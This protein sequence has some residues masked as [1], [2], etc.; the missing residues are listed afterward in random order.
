MAESENILLQRFVRSGDATAFSEIVRRHAGLVYGA[1]VRVLG[2]ADRAADATQETFFQ[3]VRDAGRITGSLPNWLHRVAT[4]KAVDVV[5]RDSSRRRRE[6]EYADLKQRQVGEWKELSPYVDQALDALDD[7]EREMLIRYFFE[8]RSMAE[9]AAAKGISHPTVSRRIE[10]GIG[11]LRAQLHRRGLIVAGVALTSLLG[12]NAA[13]AAPASVLQEL[14][15]MALVGGKGTVAVTAGAAATGSAA[16]G[17]GLVAAAKTKLIAV[18]AVVVLGLGGTLAYKYVNRPAENP[19]PETGTGAVGVSERQPG[20][21]PVVESAAR[22]DEM[23]ALPADNDVKAQRATPPVETAGIQQSAGAL[24]PGQTKPPSEAT[25]DTRS[26]QIDLSSPEA[27]V[28]SFTRLMATGNAEAVM[29]CF[30][31][32]GLDYQDMRE[33]LTADPSDPR[34]RDKY[35]TRL[36]LQSFDPEAKMPIIETK[37]KAD[38]VVEITWEVVFKKDL[39]MEGQTFTAGQ[40][41]NLDASLVKSDGRWLINGL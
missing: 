14:A 6:A 16:A 25:A 18:A 41:M 3:F 15:K 17:I 20:A 28:R 5:R 21:Q 10:K 7:E 23:A 4:G 11:E 31:P 38:G 1:C 12:E 30:L 8:G 35:E 40:T 36:W 34:Q 19:S 32:G 29:A 22:S 39:T 24:P 13:Q 2:D 37:Q 33:I 27:T 9:I 26:S